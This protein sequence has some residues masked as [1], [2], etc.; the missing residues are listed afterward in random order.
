MWTGRGTNPPP[1]GISRI[2][3]R[4]PSGS[5]TLRNGRWIIRWKLSDASDAKCVFLNNIA[6]IGFVL[7]YYNL[8]RLH[9][10]SGQSSQW[11]KWNVGCA[12]PEFRVENLPPVALQDFIFH[13]NNI[14][15]WTYRGTIP[16]PDGINF[17]GHRAGDFY[18]ARLSRIDDGISDETDLILIPMNGAP[19]CGF[20][21]MIP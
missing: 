21:A 14:F 9:R 16:Q 15:L 5:A 20:F 10:Q 8:I 11:C 13:N 18:K 7:E 12:P 2:P 19:E 4:W 1:G 17:R 6:I 3:T